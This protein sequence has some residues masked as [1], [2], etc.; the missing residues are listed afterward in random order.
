MDHT[1]KRVS[2]PNSHPLWRD[3]IEDLNLRPVDSDIDCDIAIIGGGFTGLWSAYHLINL[4][5]TLK[6]VVLESQ[7]IG[8][9]ASGRNGGWVSADYPVDSE[10]L[11]HRYPDRDVSGFLTLLRDGVNEIG[12]FC[13]DHA[14]RA[15]YRKAGA[16][17]FATNER[18]MKRLQTATDDFHSLLNRKETQEKVAID[19]AIGS[20]FTKECATVNPRGLLFDL[21][22]LLLRLGVKIYEDSKT[23]QVG[24]VLQVN[25][26]E[27]HPIWR[28]FATEAFSLKDRKQIPL[29]SLMIS[30]RQ[31]LESERKGIGW[32]PGLALAEATRNVNYAQLTSEYRIAAGGRGARYPYGSRTDQVFE[33]DTRTHQGLAEML[34]RW[35]PQLTSSEPS[36]AL[37]ITHHWGGPIAIRRDWESY[38][39][40]DKQE[41][42]A[43]LGGYVGDGMTM[44][45]L[46]A[47]EVA[48]QV[49]TGENGWAEMPISSDCRATK[50]WPIEPFRYLGANMMISAI[51]RADRLE[52]EGK[53]PLMIS[54]VES[55]LGK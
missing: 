22:N 2:P 1:A 32:E 7:K 24:E 14:P 31:L 15:Q 27:I 5:S 19:S 34:V 54:G 45:Y 37:A 33:A 35:F 47:R 12:R 42:R 6:I 16:L 17:L 4:D 26:Y 9:G 36:Q 55:I 10:T 3:G 40:V 29:Y 13:L 28:I 50:R 21:A 43:R 41:R 25:S 8:F 51:K 39:C 48:R 52:R 11:R 23:E 20:L 18:Q 46:A 30:T 38:I 49:I 44:S 53:R